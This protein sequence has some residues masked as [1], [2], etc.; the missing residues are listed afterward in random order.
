MQEQEKYLE[1]P[2][3]LYPDSPLIQHL[4][5]LL[6]HLLSFTCTFS[7]IHV[8]TLPYSYLTPTCSH[9]RHN[10]YSATHTHTVLCWVSVG[11]SAWKQQGSI[12]GW[13]VRDEEKAG[14]G[15]A[16]L[17]LGDGSIAWLPSLCCQ[18]KQQALKCSGLGLTYYMDRDQKKYLLHKTV[19]LVFFFRQWKPQKNTTKHL[20]EPWK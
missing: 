20:Y 16:S 8:H 3:N 1:H 6:Y 13:E 7:H 9:L 18:C 15:G 5:H 2:Y 14:G 4:L 10:S 12:R 11:C 19:I 17:Q